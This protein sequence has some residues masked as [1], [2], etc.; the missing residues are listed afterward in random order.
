MLLVQ[1]NSRRRKA[2]AVGRS[3]LRNVSQRDFLGHSQTST[4]SA[5]VLFLERKSRRQACGR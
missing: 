1:E 5:Q 3:L 4:R 2:G